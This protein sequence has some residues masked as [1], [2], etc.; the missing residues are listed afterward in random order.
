MRPYLVG[1]YSTLDLDAEGTPHIVYVYYSGHRIRYAHKTETRWVFSELE[2]G[3]D[4]EIDVSMSLDSAGRPHVSYWDGIYYGEAHDLKYGWFDGAQWHTTLVDAPGDIGRGSSIAVDSRDHPHIAYYDETNSALRYAHFDGQQ[5]NVVTLD[6]F[7]FISFNFR[8]A[9]A[10]D[11]QDRVHIAYSTAFLDGLSD[12]GVLKYARL[13]PSGWHTEFVDL[14]DLIDSENS[15][16]IDIDIHGIP[17]V[18]Y[19]LSGTLNHGIG[20]AAPA[21]V[22]DPS[23]RVG[24]GPGSVWLSAPFPNPCRNTAAIGFRL[25]EAGDVSR[26]LLDVAGRRVATVASGPYAAGEHLVSLRGLARPGVYLCRLAV[27][28]EERGRKLVV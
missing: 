20:P 27:G 18:A 17:H 5:W 9:I 25:G 10:I 21:G 6:D 13:D 14:G 4:A 8:T 3:D 28:G 12:T 22:G 19:S 1:Q 24:V 7:E 15:N 23:P 11:A 16:S 26:E 2:E